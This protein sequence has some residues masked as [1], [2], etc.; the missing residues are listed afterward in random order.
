[1]GCKCEQ[2]ECLSVDREACS[3]DIMLP[4]QADETGSWKVQIEFNGTW[5]RLN[6][7]VS[8]GEPIS[9]PNVLNEFYVHTI[10]LLRS[11]GSLF[12]DTCYKLITKEGG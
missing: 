6:T 11:D 3:N 1:M 12:N 8:Q 10:R 9:I 2:Y 4:I 7:E 5:I